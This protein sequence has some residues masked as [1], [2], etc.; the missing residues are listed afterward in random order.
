MKLFSD[1]FIR[2]D[3]KLKIIPTCKIQK[4]YVTVL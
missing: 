3:K 4:L 2:G 1:N